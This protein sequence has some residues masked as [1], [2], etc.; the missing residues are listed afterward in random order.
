MGLLAAILAYLG[1]VTAI[2]VTVAV[3]YD[4]FIYTPLHSINPQHTV[5]VAA[6]SVPAPSA[7]KRVLSASAA[8]IASRS[9][10]GASP[11]HDAAS[12]NAT[13]QSDVTAERRAAH[14]RREAARQK[15]TRRVA[16]QARAREWASQQAPS[17]LGYADEPP[18]RLYN[19]FPYQ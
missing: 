19:P 2:V 17:R 12:A 5:T 8:K 1:T 14:L 3:S 15:Y 10:P 18:E 4:V 6:K 16:R 11:S 13:P 9:S 7:A